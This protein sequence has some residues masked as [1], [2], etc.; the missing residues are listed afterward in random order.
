[1]T[2]ENRMGDSQEVEE[3]TSVWFVRVSSS[4]PETNRKGK[5]KQRETRAI[6]NNAG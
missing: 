3:P 2:E 1:M 4:F 6:V 5:K